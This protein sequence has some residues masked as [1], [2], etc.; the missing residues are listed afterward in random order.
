MLWER[1]KTKNWGKTKN[2]VYITLVDSDTINVIYMKIYLLLKSLKFN[3][4]ILKFKFYR[5]ILQKNET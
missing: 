4:F 1:N 3:I 2:S 5:K